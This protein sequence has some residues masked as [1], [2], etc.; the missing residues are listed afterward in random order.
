MPEAYKPDYEK[1]KKEFERYTITKESILV[2][3]SCGGGFLVRW[4]SENK[5][6]VNKLILVAPWMDPD[7]KETTDFFE[8]AIDQSISKR[9]T[10]IYLFVSSDD[11]T[12]GVKESVKIIVNKIPSI[13]QQKFTDR[14]HFIFQEMRKHEFPELLKVILD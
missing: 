5:V 14:G 11:T 6:N 2:G 7:R 1:W 10:S 9:I 4:L 8:F 12:N 3:H 13:D